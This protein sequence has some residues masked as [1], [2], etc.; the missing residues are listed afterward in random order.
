MKRGYKCVMEKTIGKN[1]LF[2]FFLDGHFEIFE[3]GL[4]YASCDN[5]QE[6]TQEISFYEEA[7]EIIEGAKK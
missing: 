1:K 3:N 4:F 5:M 7:E 2:V 6:V